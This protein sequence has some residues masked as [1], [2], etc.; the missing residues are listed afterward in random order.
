MTEEVQVS[1]LDEL[2]DV[3]LRK[4]PENLRGKALQGALAK[5]AKPIIATARQLAPSKSGRLRK[6]IYSFRDR[7]STPTRESRLISVRRGK[8][9]Q[10]NNR[11]AYYWKFVEFGHGPIKAKSG[12]SLGNQQDGFFGNEV[13]AVPPRP[14]MRPAFET[15]K[16]KA[17]DIVK[18]ELAGQIDKVAKKAVQRSATR[19]GRALRKSTIGL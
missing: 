13:K 18:A 4:L 12:K 7:Q 6:A 16:L 9:A 3:L 14:F 2:R 19:L 8:K 5:A 11:D 10:K 17:I 15:N 1:G